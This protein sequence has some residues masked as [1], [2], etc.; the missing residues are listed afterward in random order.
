MIKENHPLKALNT[1]RISAQA[2]YFSRIES[3]DSLQALLKHSTFTANP[4]LILGSGSNILFTQDYPGWV[5]HNQIKGID[6]AKENTESIWL[7]IGGGHNWNELV[8]YC[9]KHGYYGIENLSLIPGTAGAAPIQNIGAYGVELKDVFESLTAVHL[10]NGREETFSH[11][12]CLFSYRDS[13]F[14][15]ALKN[16]YF[17]TDITLRLHKKP[18]YSLSYP[19]LQQY[20][21]KHNIKESLPNISQAICDIRRSKLPDPATTPNAGSFFKNPIITTDQFQEIKSSHPKLPHYP[22]DNSTVKIPAAWLIEQCGYKGKQCGTAK[23]HSKQALVLIN[24]DGESGQPLLKL[25]QR[26][27]TSIKTHFNI[28][29]ETEVNIL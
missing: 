12:N 29:L 21:T 26:I 17:I 11:Q 19:A 4:H 10:I 25:A 15:H 1:F 6:V 3:A 18:S 8:Q 20:L 27:Q 7:R 24:Q 9:V 22:V 16:Q 14:K 5:I 2:K 28:E 23:V 13:V